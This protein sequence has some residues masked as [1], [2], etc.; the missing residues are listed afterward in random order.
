MEALE[1]IKRL[2]LRP[3]PEG[4][5]FRE[6]YRAPLKIKPEGFEIT[7]SACTTIYFLL[8][9]DSKSALH[10]IDADEQWFFLEGDPFS[11]FELDETNG[12]LK[13]TVLSHE[14]PW[15]LVP[16]GTWF[17]SKFTGTRYSLSAAV[18]APGFDFSHFTLAS[19]SKMTLRYPRLIDFFNEMC[20]L[21]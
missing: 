8:H 16:A 11:V 1:I 19:K 5:F 7:R 14:H 2:D 15:H 12:T 17:G 13:E 3:H 20:E 18:V 9:K 10:K 4:G 6:I 21:D